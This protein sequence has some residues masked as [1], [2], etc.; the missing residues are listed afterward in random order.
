MG[1][2]NKTL[3]KKAQRK[4][5]KLKLRNSSSRLRLSIFKSNNYLY[6]QIIDDIKMITLACASTQ[7]L[8]KENKGSFCN[9]ETA[10]ELGKMISEAAKNVIAEHPN[11]VNDNKLPVIYDIGDK[12]YTGVVKALADSAREQ[13]V[14]DF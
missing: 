1:Y 5:Y 11:Y 13:G 14:L 9:K 12:K 10:V 3:I 6:A 8:K 4:R 7:S 2:V